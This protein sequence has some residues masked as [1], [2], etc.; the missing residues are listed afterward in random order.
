MRRP[1]RPSRFVR[2]ASSSADFRPLA[3]SAATDTH[4]STGAA[5]P[6]APAVDLLPE[7]P[8]VPSLPEPAGFGLRLGVEPLAW[9]IV[10]IIAAL[11]RLAALGVQPLRLGDSAR[12]YAAWQIAEGRLP[13][14]W[15]GSLPDTVTAALFKLV[16]SGDGIA[17][18]PAAL[19][20]I[21]LV[22][23]IWF[24]RPVLGRAPALLAAL[25]LALSPACVAVAR[26]LSPYSAGPLAAVAVTAAMFAFLD[27]P[28]PAPLAYLAFFLG[29]GFS[30]DA[31]F[32]VFVLLVA[33]FCLV[34]IYRRPDGD[35]RAGLNYLREHPASL[36]ALA[37]ILIAGLLLATTRF[38]IAPD[39][40]RS[41]ALSSWSNAFNPTAGSLPWHY[42]ILSLVAYEPLLL[43]AGAAETVALALRMRR[44]VATL[45]ERFLLYW[46]VGALI[47]VLI[48]PQREMG[49]IVLLLVPLALAAGVGLTRLLSRAD[50]HE[51][52]PALL[53]GLLALPILV[54]V[55]FTVEQST[56]PAGLQ[57]NDVLALVL[58]LIG[59]VA[60]L[61]LGAVWSQR[62][63]PSLL[64]A[65]ALVVGLAF[66]VHTLA[67]VGFRTGDEFLLG[68]VATPDARGL[69]EEIGPVSLTLPGPTSLSPS[70]AEPL[71]WY[72]RNE[73]AVRVEEANR[74]SGGV[75][76]PAGDA[77][78]P[79][80][81][82]VVG[83]SEVAR[84]WYPAG[85]DVG[86]IVRWVLYR[87]AWGHVD[88][89]L[90][91]F[92]IQ[93]AP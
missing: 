41:A 64:A 23:A 72:T 77:A 50:R 92:M 66:A 19:C 27:R 75:V 53:P 21:A 42:P 82:T 84:S 30:S 45:F 49:Q 88:G 44:G 69:A 57:T 47:F 37:L 74:S 87:Q 61:S 68:P 15:S 8:A 46:T 89:T 43:L 3:N 62:S 17:R 29:L 14:T 4:E 9:S 58:L 24:L 73:L 6:A 79:S 90:A 1:R 25:L 7:P 71:R 31:T 86:G 5:L 26:S 85:V 20:G 48:V 91:R 36:R 10:I 60:L 54:Y 38:G 33:L 59:G 18:L 16:G 80:F 78:P 22:G 34:E 13:D 76:Q 65:C 28:R 12:A 67:G 40:L 2:A 51:L 93:Q 39:R 32:L 55:F 70:L 52:Q 81:Q 83:S 35:I 63:G 11:A 56:Q